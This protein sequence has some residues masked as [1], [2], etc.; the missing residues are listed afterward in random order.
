M[1]FWGI[2]S[3]QDA[4]RLTIEQIVYFHDYLIIV[5]IIIMCV[6]GYFIGF[7]LFTKTFSSRI[8][9][10]H[11][12]E[13]VWTILPIVVL[14]FLVYPSIYLLYLVDER[15]VEFLCTL[16]VIGHQWYWRYKIDGVLNLDIDSYM[17][18]D[19]VVRLI[20]VDNRVVVPAQEPI[21][22]LITSGDV[23]HSWALPSLGV[24]IDAI[25]GRLNQ[26]VF[27]VILNSVV[28]GQCSE[29][30]GVNHSFIPIVLEAVRL[31]DLLC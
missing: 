7:V 20:D 16:K 2:Y 23:L 1:I 13:S 26:F 6:V 15:R 11:L 10:D 4:L 25:P 8:V 21:R 27:I 24:K 5:I 30:C 19:R 17:D 31:S 28:H 18:A 14:I 12:V 22:A 3:L 9:A 29:I